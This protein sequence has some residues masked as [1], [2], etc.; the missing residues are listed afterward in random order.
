M[1]QPWLFRRIMGILA[2]GMAQAVFAQAPVQQSGGDIPL[3]LSQKQAFARSLVEDPSVAKRIQTSQDVEAQRLFA[4]AGDSYT[5]ALVALTVGDFAG[6]EKLFNEAMSAIGKARRRV[7]DTEALAIKQ[8][9][10]YGKL[11][12]SVESLEK[13]YRS[14]LKRAKPPSSTL[15]G[16]T[17][18]RASL[19]IARLVD[20]AKMHAQEN[21]MGDALQALEKAEQVMKSALGRIL[22]S[23]TIEYTQKFE[24]PAEEYSFELERNRSYL[25]L[26]PVAIAELKPTEDAKQ[27][28][29]SLV[30]QDR[31]AIDLAREYAKLQDYRKALAN[32][33][34][35]T[36]YLQLA[37]ST[38]GLVLSKG[39]GAE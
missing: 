36:G 24:S 31:A 3:G 16:E 11:L 30:E 6:A 33:R 38:A 29:E 4:L 34:A 5:G 32:V 13:S 35:G 25:E 10:D 23:T 27:T 15:G 18:E 39:A 9:A 21:R 1:I 37:L 20:A 19:G 8:R 14:Y 22:G 17:E 2:L 28:I 12:E 7:P 26:I